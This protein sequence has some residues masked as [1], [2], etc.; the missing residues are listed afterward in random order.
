M[1]GSPLG[2]LDYIRFVGLDL[3]YSSEKSIIV[4]TC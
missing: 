4:R 2:G 3:L 1:I